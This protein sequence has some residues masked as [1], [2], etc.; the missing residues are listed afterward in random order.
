MLFSVNY[1]SFLT[2]KFVPLQPEF[3]YSKKQLNA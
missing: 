1:V 2:K 3:I